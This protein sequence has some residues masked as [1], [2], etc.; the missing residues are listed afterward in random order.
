MSPANTE[1]VCNRIYIGEG[2]AYPSDHP[3]RLGN[4]LV[5]THCGSTRHSQPG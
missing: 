5:L 1:Q 2:I 4:S 3:Q